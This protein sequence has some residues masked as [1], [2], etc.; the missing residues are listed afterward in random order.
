MILFFIQDEQEVLHME[1]SD[2]SQ[3]S[4]GDGNIF[5]YL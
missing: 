3:G 5:I 4:E 2:G 1:G